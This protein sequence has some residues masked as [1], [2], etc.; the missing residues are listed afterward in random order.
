MTDLRENLGWLIGSIATAIAMAV[1]WFISSGVVVNLL[2]LLIGSGITYFVQT[3]TQK[4]AWKRE[5]SVRIA[6]E[7][8]G[9]LF[10]GVKGIILSLKNK[11][12]RHTD[13]SV[14][15][16]MQDDHRYFMVDKGFRIK[17]DQF[18]ERLEKYSRTVVKVRVEIL[19][20]IVLEE[21]ERVFGVKTDDIPRV[22]VTYMKGRRLVSSPLNLSNCI[23]SETHPIKHATRDEPDVSEVSFLLAVKPIGKAGATNYDKTPEL[24]KFWQSSLKRIRQDESYKFMVEENNTLLEEARKLKQEIAN[25]IEEPWKI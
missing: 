25:R 3:R 12:Y 22:K 10:R 1:G 17:L 14:W 9:S 21:T 24:N 18:R 11:W 19:P 5:Y 23:V 20:K 15:R 16:E 7:V 6:E 8:Y 13:F 4:R 2:F